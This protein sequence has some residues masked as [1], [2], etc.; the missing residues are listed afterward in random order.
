MMNLRENGTIFI[1]AIK[2]IMNNQLQL[3]M[4]IFQN[5][6]RSKLRHFKILSTL[7]SKIMVLSDLPR[8]SLVMIHLMDNYMI[9]EL[10]LEM[11]HSLRI[12]T[13]S[14][15]PSLIN[16]LNLLMIRMKEL[17]L[18]LKLLKQD[19]VVRTLIRLLIRN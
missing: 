13:N 3:P 6:I 14:E 11:V 16:Y 18:T 10:H 5:L 9:P 8:K 12:Q 4:S 15:N 7:Y 17:I 19:L 2:D 1:F